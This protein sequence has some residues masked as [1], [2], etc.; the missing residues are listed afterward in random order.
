MTLNNAKLCD[1]WVVAPDESAMRAANVNP[2]T[3][4]ATDFLNLFN[5]YIMLGEM[6]ADGS[7]PPDV[8]DDWKP[9]D[10]ETHFSQSG[11][12]GSEV[13]LAS[14]RALEC[15]KRHEFE[16][17]NNALIELILDH[18]LSDEPSLEQI[19]EIKIQRDLLSAMISGPAALVETGCEDAQAAID[20][21][22][23]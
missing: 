11:F 5:E 14:Y 16:N 12:A 4:L 7:M 9:V 15:S 1:D 13:V 20:A 22:F 17:I 6:V 8:L 19:H 2:K 10:Y 23:D 3:G 21:L 18:Q